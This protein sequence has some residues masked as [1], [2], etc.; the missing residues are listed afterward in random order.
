MKYLEKEEQYEEIIK[1]KLTLVDFYADW[2]GP[3]QMMGEELEKLEKDMKELNIVKVNVDKCGN[4]ARKF[5]IMTIPTI[6]I[7]KES[8]EVDSNVGFLTKDEIKEL[9]K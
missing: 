6:K 3:C 2:C 8:V 1:G 7:Y 9:L 5:G 4:L